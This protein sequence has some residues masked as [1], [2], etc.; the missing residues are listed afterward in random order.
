MQHKKGQVKKVL[1]IKKHLLGAKLTLCV[2][3]FVICT[4]STQLNKVQN[5]TK[6]RTTHQCHLK[7]SVWMPGGSCYFV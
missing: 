2:F 5:Y 1:Q 7:E 3:V 6:C 4:Q